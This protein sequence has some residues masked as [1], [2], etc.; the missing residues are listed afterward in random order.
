MIEKMSVI[1]KNPYFLP[2]NEIEGSDIATT[3]QFADADLFPKKFF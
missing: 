2:L 3:F 1:G